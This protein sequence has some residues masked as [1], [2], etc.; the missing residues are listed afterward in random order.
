[1][2]GAF[3]LYFLY[4]YRVLCVFLSSLFS[5]FVGEGGNKNLFHV[6]LV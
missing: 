6:F 4:L 2:W 1:M 5:F 3:A